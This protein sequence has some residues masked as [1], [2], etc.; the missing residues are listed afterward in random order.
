MTGFSREEVLGKSAVALGIWTADERSALVARL[1]SAPT[2]G[3]E[4]P[5]RTKSGRSLTMLLASA[6]IDFGGE[7]CLINV[8][9]DVTERHAAEA[10]ARRARRWRA[11]GPTS[12]PR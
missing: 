11:P 12:S 1:Q 9:T 5:Y 3:A 6:R 4:L 7:P 10:A 2:A 8:A